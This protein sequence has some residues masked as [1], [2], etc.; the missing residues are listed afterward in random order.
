MFTFPILFLFFLTFFHHAASVQNEKPQQI[1]RSDLHPPSLNDKWFPNHTPIPDTDPEMT[2][3]WDTANTWLYT[4]RLRILFEAVNEGI[5]ARIAS[6]TG[7]YDPLPA[8]SAGIQKFRVVALSGMGIEIANLVGH[9]IVWGD[10]EDVMRGLEH[11]P[12]DLKTLCT[13][14][15]CN[16]QFS[17]GHPGEEQRVGWG[18]TFKA[19]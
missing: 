3:Y 18:R 10:L 11:G 4:E 8:S 6:G 15:L 19:R 13:G 12:G 7:R 9:Q 2:I 16:F 17:L 14:F 1:A 5:A